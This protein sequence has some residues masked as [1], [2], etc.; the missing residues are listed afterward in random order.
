MILEK[1]TSSKLIPAEGLWQTGKGK[2][3]MK[4]NDMNVALDRQRS[5]Q[6]F[7][8]ARTIQ[9]FIRGTLV[10]LKY[11]GA[12]QERIKEKKRKAAE[13]AQRELEKIKSIKKMS[14]SAVVIQKT[15]RGYFA[16][17][18]LLFCCYCCCCCCCYYLDILSLFFS[19]IFYSFLIPLMH[20]FFCK[21]FELCER[22]AIVESS[23]YQ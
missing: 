10:R 6:C 8:F 4:T 21:D 23:N 13:A 19:I 18:V 1:A 2:V 5:L 20:F 7:G 9:A 15:F 16:K 12:R 22:S 11:S 17:K 14:F 3:F